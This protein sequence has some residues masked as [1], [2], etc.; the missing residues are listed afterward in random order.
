MK[1]AVGSDHRGAELASQVLEALERHGHHVLDLTVDGSEPCDYPDRAFDVARRVAAGQADR[2]VLVCGTGIGMSIAAN[3]IDGVLAALVHDE[4]SAEISRR[5]NNS[6][7][8]C[9][10][11]EM[12][13]RSTVDRI[14]DIWLNTA[15]DGG[16]H[17]R[18]I[19]KINAAERRSGRGSEPVAE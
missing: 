14:L 5:H 18:R 11:G 9:L 15:F 3:K 13:G 4:V 16:R 17:E 12:L 19:H 1:V 10:S 6:N 8:L 2:G 7:V